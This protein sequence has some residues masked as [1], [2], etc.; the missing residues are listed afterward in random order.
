MV[1]E[2]RFIEQISRNCLKLHHFIDLA[3]LPQLDGVHIK[4]TRIILLVRSS[5]VGW[6]WWLK[7][8]ISYR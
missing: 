7:R 6:D 2:G 4:D 5:A 8:P 1:V 3:V